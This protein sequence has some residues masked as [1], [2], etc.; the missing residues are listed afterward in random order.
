MI[1]EL[2]PNTKPSRYYFPIRNRIIS[3]LSAG[4]VIIEAP[5][6]SGSLLTAEH[7]L[8]QGR[9]VFCIPPHEVMS[10][11]YCGVIPLLREGAIPAYSYADIA[12]RYKVT[13]E[14]AED[15]VK[16]V[17]EEAELYNIIESGDNLDTI[18]DKCSLDYGE[19]SERLTEF[20]LMGL[21]VRSADGVYSKQ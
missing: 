5:E 14:I 16:A 13:V 18:M 6:R 8:A 1:S 4:T 3:G 9:D 21:L 19:L 7:S 11:R 20:E 17:T 10:K 2:F 15:E 12:D